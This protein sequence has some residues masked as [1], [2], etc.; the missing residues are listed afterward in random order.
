MNIRSCHG[1]IPDLA[2]TR[3][4]RRDRKKEV[5]MMSK[6]HPC[7][8]AMPSARGTFGVSMKPN[9]MRTREKDFPRGS[10]LTRS[11][12]LTWGVF[13]ITTVS[14]TLFSCRTL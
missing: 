12:V 7:L 2:S 10:M 5:D 1:G 13:S 3:T 8:R 14:T 11:A 9:R 4:E 6:L